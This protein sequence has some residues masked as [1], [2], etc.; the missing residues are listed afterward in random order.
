MTMILSDIPFNNINSF[1]LVTPDYLGSN[2]SELNKKNLK[3]RRGIK[4]II[5]KWVA[6]ERP[7]GP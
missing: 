5:F 4:K 7:E 6:R 3:I 2:S 1:S